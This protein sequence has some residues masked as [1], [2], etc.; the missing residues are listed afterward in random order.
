VNAGCEISRNDLTIDFLVS[1]NDC[2]LFE[3]SLHCE[4]AEQ[5]NSLET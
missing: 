1:Y 5:K 4:E 2:C 3:G